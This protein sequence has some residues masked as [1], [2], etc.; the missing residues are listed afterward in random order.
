MDSILLFLLKIADFVNNPVIIGYLS[1]FKGFG[2]PFW[3]KMDIPH[4]LL[5]GGYYQC[6]N[7]LKIDDLF[8]KKTCIRSGSHKKSK[9]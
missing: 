3:G 4:I 6:E 7:T 8:E 2:G 5:E 1:E 9:V